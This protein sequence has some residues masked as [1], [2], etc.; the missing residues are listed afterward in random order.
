MWFLCGFKKPVKNHKIIIVVI[1][2]FAYH[3]KFTGFLLL[4][5]LSGFK[6]P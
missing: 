5:F 1:Y 6:K 2:R 3:H 4:R